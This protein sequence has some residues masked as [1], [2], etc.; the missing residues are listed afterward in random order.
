MK[1]SLLPLL[2]GILIVFGLFSYG[3][4][5]TS[6]QYASEDLS[7]KSFSM[8][9][10]E[11]NENVAV[12]STLHTSL[13]KQVKTT[14]TTKNTDSHH[15]DKGD[16]IKLTD[17]FMNEVIQPT[18]ENNKVNQFDTKDGLINHLSQYASEDLSKYYVDGL[19]EEKK[20]GL[21]II[22][23]ELPP[24][25]MKGEPSELVKLDEENYQLNQENQSDLYGNY[26]IQVSFTMDNDRWKIQS[27]E[28]K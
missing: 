25:V 16:F 6:K 5:T 12:A 22:P 24:W 7:K 15:P 10:I 20:D 17:T 18:G 9:P 26:F 27:A 3:E 21:Y 23:T 13:E 2:I 4:Q 28:V 14:T 19:Y 11:V 1:K 8:E